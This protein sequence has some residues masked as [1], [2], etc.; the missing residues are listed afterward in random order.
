MDTSVYIFVI[1]LD[2]FIVF[3][4]FAIYLYVLFRYFLHIVEANGIIYFFNMH[5]QIYKPFL[6]I[7]KNSKKQNINNTKNEN[8]LS[9]KLS[10]KLQNDI[11]NI[12]E[13]HDDN[14][15]NIGT[16]LILVTILG[17]FLIILIYFGLCYKKII[18]QLSLMSIFYTIIINLIFIVGIELVFLFFV[19]CS[20]DVINIKHV[21]GL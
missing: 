15:F 20:I 5:L 3:T 14:N 11:N 21:L 4:I 7:L 2:V 10:N 16:I 8:E 17:L 13:E 9:N 19:Y 18:A 6:T 12:E 1:L